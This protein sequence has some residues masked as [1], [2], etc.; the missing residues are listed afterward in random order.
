MRGADGI[1]NLQRVRKPRIRAS[2]PRRRR[3]PPARPKKKTW[4]LHAKLERGKVV[5][6]D[7]TARAEAVIDRIA[8]EATRPLEGGSSP[9]SLACAVSG[10][11]GA[12]GLELGGTYDFERTSS[13]P[14]C[15]HQHRSRRISAARGEHEVGFDR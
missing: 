1:T 10:T 2:G 7:L 13:Q 11:R 15:G 3:G 14:S 4:G 6:R 12:G 9:F 5:L 8:I